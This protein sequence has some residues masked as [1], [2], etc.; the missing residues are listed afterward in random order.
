[1]I[2]VTVGGQMPFDRLV[3]AVD[4][5]AGEHGV[6]DVFAQIGRTDYRP[7]NIEWVQFLEPKELRRRVREARVVVAHAGIGTILTALEVGTPLLVMPRRADRRETRTDHQ[8]A[9]AERFVEA[10]RLV[11]VDDVEALA[12][13]LGNLEDLTAPARIRAHASDELLDALRAFVNGSAAADAR[14]S[15]SADSVA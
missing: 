9:T 8:V 7:E 11:A 2:L 13:R 15:R 3:T 14:S 6:T 12:A 5:W 10:G 1:M 4:R